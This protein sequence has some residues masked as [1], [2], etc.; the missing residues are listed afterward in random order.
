MKGTMT[1]KR[2]RMI[3]FASMIGVIVLGIGGFVFAHK[4]LN[5]YALA[6]SK[7]NA[8]AATGDQNIQTLRKLE[9]VLAERQDA[10]AKADSIVA[11]QAT[12]ADQAINDINRIASQ[13]GVTLSSFEFVESG[14]TGT[15]AATAAPAPTAAT[16]TT[17]TPPTTAAPAGVTQKSISI[18]LES[19]LNY[20][21]LLKFIQGIETNRLRMQI[22]NVSLT[23]DEGS[24]VATQ[25]FTIKVN[26]K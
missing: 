4:Q 18:T 9:T 23:K 2:L 12:F 1:A 20:T 6:I 10:V 17:T 24:D 15:P 19:P 13:S 14:A 11:D 8:D 25:P 21:N 5:D 22:S 7:L 16:P 3:L 26:V